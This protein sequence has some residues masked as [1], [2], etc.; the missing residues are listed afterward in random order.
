MTDDFPINETEEQV[1]FHSEDIEFVLQ[2]ATSIN[3]WI[4]SIIERENTET[5]KLKKTA[6]ELI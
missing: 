4:H 6:I 5:I 1:L 2:D 3:N